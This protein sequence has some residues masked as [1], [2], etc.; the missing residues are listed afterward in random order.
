M[1]T[2]GKLIKNNSNEYEPVFIDADGIVQKMSSTTLSYGFAG[3]CYPSKL[4]SI[5]LYDQVNFPQASVIGVTSTVNSSSTLKAWSALSTSSQVPKIGQVATGTVTLTV[6]NPY[7]FSLARWKLFPHYNSSWGSTGGSAAN[8]NTA[9]QSVDI[10]FAIKGYNFSWTDVNNIWSTGYLS[11]FEN[12]RLI[13]LTPGSYTFNYTITVKAIHSQLIVQQSFYPSLV[14]MDY[15]Q[16]SKPT[17]LL[18]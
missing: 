2:T 8:G 11:G 17:F 5:E 14:P 13:F 6:K 16:I 9:V 1:A 12:R 15:L 10:S 3:L 7:F 4:N 18:P